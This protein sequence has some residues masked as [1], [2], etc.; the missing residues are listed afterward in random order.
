MIVLQ[1][2]HVI[3]EVQVIFPSKSASV[4]GAMKHN[5]SL[6]FLTQTLCTL[7]K[8]SLLAQIKICQVSYVSLET[9]NQFL[10][11]FCIIFY[12]LDA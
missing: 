12:C 10:V 9:A 6:L 11:K 8:R 1:I 5:S 2:P 3:F 4:S 7:V